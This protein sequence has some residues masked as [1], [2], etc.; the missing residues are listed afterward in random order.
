MSTILFFMW[1]VTYYALCIWPGQSE[2]TGATRDYWDNETNA[3]RRPECR[4]LTKAYLDTMKRE[5]IPG[6]LDCHIHVREVHDMPPVS[7]CI[8]AIAK[9]S[10]AVYSASFDRDP[11]HYVKCII[12]QSA[13]DELE[14]YDDSPMYCRFIARRLLAN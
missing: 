14:L 5:F 11:M 1:H 13:I 7:E 4:A 6:A 3:A 9:M 2:Y 12:K 8:R 10:P